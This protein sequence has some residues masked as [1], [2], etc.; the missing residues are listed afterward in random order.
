M[1]RLLSILF[2]SALLP[3]V[4]APDSFQFGPFGAVPVVRPAGA[5]SRVA[6][7]LSGEQGIG[8]RESSLA[9]A[10]A[11]AG[12]L[13]F[14]V[15]TSRYFAAGQG[16]SLYPAAD[17]E[18]LS[19]IGQKELG[20]PTYRQPLLV[21][22]GAGS[23]LAYAALAE[24]PADTFSGAVSVGFCPI[25][26]LSHAL[27]RGRGL[28]R[29]KR[30]SAPGIRLLPDPGIENPWLI[31]EAPAQQCA[32]GPAADFAKSVPAA[33][34][35][36]VPAGASAEEAPNPQLAQALAILAEESQHAAGAQVARGELRDLPLTE[37]PVKRAGKDALAVIVSGSGGYVGLDRKMG[38]NIAARGVPVVGLSSLAY[39]W[40]PRD[41]DGSA[42]DLARILDHYLTAWHK[43]RAIVIGY[44]QGAD[45]VPFMVDRLPLELRSRVKLVTLI[46]P[47][48]GAQFHLHPG[49][50]IGNPQE[51]SEL[52]EAPEIPKLKGIR[53]LCVYGEREQKSLCRQLD[54]SLVKDLEVPGGHGFEGD[55]PV[56]ADRALAEAG[57]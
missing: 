7:L 35:I 42:Q 32:A 19:Q 53:V 41:P 2:L 12:A 51:R 47:D 30:W 3:A 54:P 40:K 17:F 4:A 55:A 14:E 46:G 21:G 45:V 52:P 26:P 36:P 16:Q 1:A 31:L 50:W 49:G 5:P 37:V 22:I 38:N 44:S 6:L 20:L 9:A 39:F 29:A 43:S 8:E 24:A 13:V 56:I 28:G 25:L 33:R 48:G 10:L 15:D 34:V 57:L 23:A 18:T 11:A 27:H